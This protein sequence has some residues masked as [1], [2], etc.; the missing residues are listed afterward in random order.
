MQRHN[1]NITDAGKHHTLVVVI[2]VAVLIG[3]VIS[4][5]LGFSLKVNLPS[6][7]KTGTVLSP[8]VLDLNHCNTESILRLDKLLLYSTFAGAD[9]DP[10]NS[11]LTFPF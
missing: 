1:E 7:S 11:I 10:C 9:A 6:L 4:S 8:I 5:P 3:I 2:V